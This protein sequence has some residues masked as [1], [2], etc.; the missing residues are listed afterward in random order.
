MMANLQA[1]VDDKA[2]IGREYS[3]Q[4]AGATYTVSAADNFSYTDPIDGSQASKQGIRIMFTDGSRL[5]FRLSGTGSS[6]ATVR[7]YVDSYCSDQAKVTRSAGE[8]LA[9]VVQLGLEISQL[10]ELTGRQEP[11]VVT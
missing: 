9:P 1:F 2:N 8:M 4:G 3:V 5:V 7:M 6:G 10:R 11:T